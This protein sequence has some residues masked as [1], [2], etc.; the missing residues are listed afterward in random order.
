M[1]I[2]KI[3]KA[4]DNDLIADDLYVSRHHAILTIRG[5]EYILEDLSSKNGTFVNGHQILRKRVN[6]TD[7]ILLGKQ[8]VLNLRELTDNQTDYSEEFE[9]LKEVYEKYQ[10]EKVKIQSS[11]QFK[12]RLLQSL[13]FAL[14]GMIGIGLGVTTLAGSKLLYISLLVAV[15]AP[16]AGIVL[17]AGQAA[18]IPGQLQELN[19]RFKTKYVC[20]KCGAFLGE[21][22]WQSLK[23]RGKC[24]NPSCHAE[25][26]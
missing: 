2:V 6:V 26:K 9:L 7:Q 21:I 10:S 17:G 16:V 23:N 3:G 14:P 5:G 1:M 20:P 11:N 18:K 22:P 24:P 13:P 19:D 25:W 8:Y 15:I 4:P 12:T